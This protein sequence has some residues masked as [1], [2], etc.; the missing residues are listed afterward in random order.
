[1][2]P[3]RWPDSLDAFVAAPRHHKLV[4]DNERVRVLDTRIPAR[5]L[6]NVHAATSRVC[7]PE[8]DAADS[9]VYTLISVE[10]KY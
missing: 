4:L 5:D 10:M 7:S 3:R 6:V 8:R 9:R 1:M 2:T